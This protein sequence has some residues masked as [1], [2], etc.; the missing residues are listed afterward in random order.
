MMKHFTFFSALTGF[1][2][3]LGVI[4]GLVLGTSG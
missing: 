2:F 1:G 3:L 4:S